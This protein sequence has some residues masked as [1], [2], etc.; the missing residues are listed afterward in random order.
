MSRPEVLPNEDVFL[1]KMGISRYAMKE[2]GKELPQ[3]TANE[4]VVRPEDFT[5][6][7][8]FLSKMG[9]SKRSLKD[10]PN[11]LQDSLELYWLQI[12]S[13]FPSHNFYILDKLD[14][15]NFIVQT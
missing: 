15:S 2:N 5:S 12:L 8:V 13:L 4:S 10:T 9:V 7:G 6:E 3:F 1:S 14:D 11:K